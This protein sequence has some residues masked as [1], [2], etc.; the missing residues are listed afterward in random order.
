MNLEYKGYHA[1]V[2]SHSSIG[3][4][5]GELDGISDLV[6]FQAED[7]GCAEAAFRESVDDYLNLCSEL[8]R[9]PDQPLLH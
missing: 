2:S 1:Q 4:I 9:A 8:G 7:C 3:M 5:S 6:T